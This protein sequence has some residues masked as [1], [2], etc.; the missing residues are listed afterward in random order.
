MVD[1]NSLRLVDAVSVVLHGDIALDN[2]WMGLHY[3]DGHNQEEDGEFH[4]PRA[5]WACHDIDVEL[6]ADDSANMKISISLP[7]PQSARYV[8]FLLEGRKSTSANHRSFGRIE[9]S[10]SKDGLPS[11]SASQPDG[12]S[13]DNNNDNHQMILPMTL[14]NYR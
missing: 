1:L 12:G 2:V 14:R 9:I 7:K 8:F 11:D 13:N 4:M 5:D 3:D 10:G 6:L